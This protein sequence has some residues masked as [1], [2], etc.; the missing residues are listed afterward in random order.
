MR[1]YHSSNDFLAYQQVGLLA[2]ARSVAPIIM[3][4]L[5]PS[6]V[7][8]VGCG[9]GAWVV[10]YRECGVGDVMGV[11]AGH[12]RCEQLLFDPARFHAIDVAGV[13]R[14][15]RRFDLVQCLEVAEHLDRSAGETLVDNLVAHA[16]IVLFSAAPPGEGGENHINERPYEYWRDLFQRSGYALFDFL[17][18]QV[19]FR[20]SVDHSYRYNMLLFARED[21]AA[22][23]SPAIAAT[24]IDPLAPVPD[25][26]PLGWRVR[27]RALSILP[28]ALVT[29]LALVKHSMGSRGGDSSASRRP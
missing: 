27:R 6:S 1:L 18:P 12:G 3:R 15:P 13:F 5:K 22:C 16:P 14:L 26:A 11:D 24:R 8:D 9:A 4:H 29:R 10:A 28:P 2:S 7:L 20:R 17:R 21:A 19:R 25:L 23:F